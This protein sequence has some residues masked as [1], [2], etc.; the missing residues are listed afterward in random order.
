M[1]EQTPVPAKQ[2]KTT[3]TKI[4]ELAA[5]AA[6]TAEAGSALRAL[7]HVT[8]LLA[9][10]TLDNAKA[11][12]TRLS[13]HEAEIKKLRSEVDELAQMLVAVHGMVAKPAEGQEQVGE[14]APAA[15]GAET[16]EA[17]EAAPESAPA[18]EAPVPA[19]APPAPPMPPV[20]R[21]R[22]KPAAP[23]Q[24]APSEEI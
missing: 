18:P 8:R 7:A 20:G 6:A 17:A 15:E 3:L 1:S 4:V 13:A 16:A 10:R 5:N 12:L 23:A 11:T 21:Q 14:A 9:A 2:E 24:A 22:R 19:P